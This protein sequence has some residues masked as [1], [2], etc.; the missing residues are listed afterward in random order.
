[1]NLRCDNCG[2]TYAD[3]GELA[4]VFPDIPDLPARIEPGGTVPHGE[5]PDCRARVCA[6]EENPAAMPVVV[7]VR[8]G[9]A[10]VLACPAGVSVE[11]RD[12]D[13]E[14]S[15][16]A[17]GALVSWIARKYLRRSIAC[18]TTYAHPHRR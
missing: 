15:L 4:C 2:R 13:T 9:V 3:E 11:I 10:E 16:E 8:G 18:P 6:D 5:C 7:A 17:D 1:M 14:G 12:Y